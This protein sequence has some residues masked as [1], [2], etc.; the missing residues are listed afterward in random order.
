MRFKK[1][2]ILS[3]TSF[4]FSQNHPNLPELREMYY[5]WLVDT[6]QDE[7]AGL[8]KQQQGDWHGAISLYMKAG[9]PARAAKVAL[10]RSVGFNLNEKLAF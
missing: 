10:S 2:P 3:K 6:N 1:T 7:S 8:L 5:K 4:A 9:L